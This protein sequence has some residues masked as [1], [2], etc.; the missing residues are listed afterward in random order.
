MRNFYLSLY[1]IMLLSFSSHALAQG[2][3]SVEENGRRVWTNEGPATPAAHRPA[4]VAPAP[5]VM[6]W[7][8]VEHRWKPVPL[9]GS[10][11]ML[12][13]QSAVAE[14]RRLI[15]LPAAGPRTASAGGRANPAP[16]SREIEAAIEQASARYNVDPGLVR[17]VIKVESNFNPKAISRKG[18]IGLMQLMPSTARGLNVSDPFDPR[19]NVEAGVRYLRNLLDTNNG[20]VARSL[21]AYNAGQ[22]A[23][24]RN[25]GIPPYAETRDYVRRITGLYGSG[26]GFS[27]GRLPIHISRGADGTLS[28]SNVE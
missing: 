23:V 6:Y 28:A 25:H 20:N 15:Q 19:Q 4:N 21:A 13:A 26:E 9:A 3:V 8:A 17:A 12:H 16:T 1:T 7:S 24:E 5:R 2:L 14:V 27:N 11:D 10:A 18:A 22:R